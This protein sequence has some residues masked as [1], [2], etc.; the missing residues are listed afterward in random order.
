[1][2]CFR[3]LEAS[4]KKNQRGKSNG[5]SNKFRAKEIAYKR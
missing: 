1:M 5:K 3:I 2:V 4:L